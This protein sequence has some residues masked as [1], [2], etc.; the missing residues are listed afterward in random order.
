MPTVE[1]SG[2]T[3]SYDEQGEGQQDDLERGAGVAPSEEGPDDGPLKNVYAA[4]PR[5]HAQVHWNLERSPA[6]GNRW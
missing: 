5:C 2:T 3:W 6:G 4:A 1:I